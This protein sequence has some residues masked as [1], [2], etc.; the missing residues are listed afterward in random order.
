MFCL[1]KQYLQGEQDVSGKRFLWV[2]GIFERA[3]SSPHIS[4]RRVKDEE[5]DS[6]LDPDSVIPGFCS[7]RV[8]PR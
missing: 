8:V 2:C 6:T 3:A 7:G 4:P 1:G 5:T